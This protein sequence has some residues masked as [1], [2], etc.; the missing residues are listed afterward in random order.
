MGFSVFMIRIS[1]CWIACIPH[2]CSILCWGLFFLPNT[3]TH[4]HS[5]LLPIYI[6]LFGLYLASP[7]ILLLSLFIRSGGAY[8][9]THTQSPNNNHF[10]I[11]RSI[12]LYTGILYGNGTQLFV[13]VCISFSASLLLISIH[14][15]GRSEW[16]MIICCRCWDLSILFCLPFA[17]ADGICSISN[18]IL[19][20]WDQF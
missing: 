6:A 13:T 12:S 15:F 11:H 8:Q 1:K 16:Y 14:S 20:P 18:L 5:L 3:H 4:A 17:I 9:S 10:S 19:C 2:L 7:P